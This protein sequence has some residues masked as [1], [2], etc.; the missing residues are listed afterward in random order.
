VDLK[1]ITAI[2][3]PKT[4]QLFYRKYSLTLFNPEWGDI[5]NGQIKGSYDLNTIKSILTSHGFKVKTDPAIF[6]YREDDP[7][8]NYLI[9]SKNELVVKINLWGNFI[10]VTFY[11]TY[12]VTNELGPRYGFDQYERMTY[13]DRKRCD[14]YISKLTQHFLSINFEIQNNY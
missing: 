4:I 1:E 8:R 10:R 9:G 13:L 3:E 12:N 7:S 14:L 6:D 11:P 5:Y 2:V